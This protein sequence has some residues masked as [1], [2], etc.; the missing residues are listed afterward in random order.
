MEFPIGSQAGQV[1]VVRLEREGLYCRVQAKCRDLGPGVHRL[2]GIYGTESRPLGVFCPEDGDLALERR[3]S[4]RQLG[5]PE[6]FVAGRALRGWRPWQGRLGGREIP[7]GRMGPDGLALPLT[8]GADLPWV[9]HMGAL[10]PLELEDGHWVIVP[11][12]LWDA[13]DPAPEPALPAAPE[14]A[15][16]PAPIQAAEAAQA[17]EA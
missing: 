5:S 13:P 16:P 14:T 2:W 6:A 11:P 15:E 7:W 3:L 10:A 12:A 17:P 4:A 8:P 9:A 1:G